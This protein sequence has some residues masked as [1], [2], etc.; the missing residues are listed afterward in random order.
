M[1]T[2]IYNFGDDSST[3]QIFM[4]AC[5]SA[6]SATL[7][8]CLNGIEFGASNHGFNA[9]SA[10]NENHWHNVFEN[11]LEDV[12]DDIADA[13]PHLNTA[14]A[15]ERILGYMTPERF[16]E[17]FWTYHSGRPDDCGPKDSIERVE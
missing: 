14:K 11:L 17:R 6:W 8:F 15:K 16:E 13:L 5:E 1:H 9:W 4:T 7:R 3:V 12:F 2:I 10:V